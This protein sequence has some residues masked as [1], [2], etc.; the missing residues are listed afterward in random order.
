LNLLIKKHVELTISEVDFIL[1]PSLRSFWNPVCVICN[2]AYR[3]SYSV[4]CYGVT[5][6]F[7]YICTCWLFK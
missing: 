1:T 6:L 3:C 5:I 2:N 7:A 4:V